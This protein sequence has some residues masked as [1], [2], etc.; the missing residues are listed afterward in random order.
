MLDPT[1]LLDETYWKCYFE[2]IKSKKYIL[3]YQ[4]HNDKNLGDYAKKLAKTKKLPLI[5]ISSS[6]HQII[7]GGRFKWCPTIGQFLSYLK[8]AECIITDSFHGTAFAI[9]FNTPFIEII[10]N[11][12]TETR[13]LSILQLTG[14]TER[15]LYNRNN[16]DLINKPIDFSSANTILL[17]E[18]KKSINILKKMIEE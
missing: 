3:V 10:P 18:R 9:N 8:N 12:G 2:P 13:N 4:L 16:L 14:L 11:N 15:I 7:R 1:L 6:F 5:R 17:Q